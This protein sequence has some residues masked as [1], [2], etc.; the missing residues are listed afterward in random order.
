VGRGGGAA[1]HR[2]PGDD[3]R[4]HVLKSGW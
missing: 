3:N 4:V 1:T 2:W